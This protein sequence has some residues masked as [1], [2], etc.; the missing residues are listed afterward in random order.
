[1]GAIGALSVLLVLISLAPTA[2]GQESPTI[3]HG[4]VRAFTAALT[5]APFAAYSEDSTEFHSFNLYAK[6][7]HVETYE[8]TVARVSTPAGVHY[9]HLM[10]TERKTFPLHDV[11]IELESGAAS[12]YLGLYG[13]P[14]ASAEVIADDLRIAPSRASTI[15]N[16]PYPE[17]TPSPGE[18]T[19]GRSITQDHLRVHA[20][21]DVSIIYEGPGSVKMR[22]VVLRQTSTEN[23]T[24]IYALDD[25]PP[26]AGTTKYR[27][28]FLSWTE[29]GFNLSTSHGAHLLLPKGDL[30]AAKARAARGFEVAGET[31]REIED[32]RA[33]LSP[34]QDDD[35]LATRLTP[36]PTTSYTAGTQPIAASASL[37]PWPIILVGAAVLALGGSSTLAIVRRSRNDPAP[38]AGGDSL[39]P[40]AKVGCPSGRSARDRALLAEAE[41]DIERALACY[42]DADAAVTHGGHAFCA[43]MLA[44][45]SGPEW[46][47]QTVAFIGRALAKTP[48]L[49][50]RLNQD[51]FQHLEG[52][53]EYE[54]IRNTALRSLP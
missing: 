1:M 50:Y 39:E 18:A 8:M 16:D 21:Q 40:D 17:R 45:N 32:L 2:I 31:I 48:R 53:D 19:Y 47:R 15:G 49:V 20:S 14:H 23:S 34:H 38:V 51:V 7:L 6:D 33:T 42:D 41:G 52:D 11:H 5:A 27:W 12:G 36:F 29:G 44:A 25:S 43:A 10:G 30:E 54:E 13:D 37:D 28:V 22:G 26:T 4:D 35:E 24:P 3:A 46:R 9:E